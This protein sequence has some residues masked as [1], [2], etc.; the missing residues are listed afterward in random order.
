MENNKNCTHFGM[1][2]M[3]EDRHITRF[4]EFIHHAQEHGDYNDPRSDTGKLPK[5]LQIIYEDCVYCGE[6]G[7][8]Y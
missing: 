7:E 6:K 2:Q 4:E 1:V 5:E 3:D 8:R